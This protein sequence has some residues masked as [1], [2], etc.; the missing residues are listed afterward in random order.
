[1]DV[2]LEFD[3]NHDPSSECT[4][5][6]EDNGVA[7]VLQH[8][9]HVVHRV[10]VHYEWPHLVRQH[11]G[12]SHAG[13][14]PTYAEYGFSTNE[15]PVSTAEGQRCLDQ[16]AGMLK[17][18]AGEFDPLEENQAY[19]HAKHPCQHCCLHQKNNDVC[20][21]VVFT[22]EDVVCDGVQ[23]NGCAIV[24]E[25]LALNLHCQS[26]RSAELLEE[27][28]DSHWISGAQDCT[29]DQAEHETPVVR[30]INPQE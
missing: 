10:L 29:S 9:P 18:P 11:Q 30:Q 24:Q 23:H 14:H 28:N 27:G 1:M 7:Q 4:S 20:H 12:G 15:A 25:R 26:G 6:K 13:K 17:L 22:L 16:A 5:Q 21:I 3:P 2:I 19:N 8:M